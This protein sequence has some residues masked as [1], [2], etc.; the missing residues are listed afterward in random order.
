MRNWFQLMDGYLIWKVVPPDYNNPF[1]P[2]VSEQ[3][4]HE[5][6]SRRSALRR[7]CKLKCLCEG[8]E[9]M[10]FDNLDDPGFFTDHPCISAM[11]THGVLTYVF[12][13]EV[14]VE[15]EEQ[16][17]K[18]EREMR[19]LLAFRE[20]NLSARVVGWG[21]QITIAEYR[22]RRE[23]SKRLLAT[24]SG[25]YVVRYEHTGIA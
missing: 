11:G 16:L 21:D 24:A 19:E 14:N 3:V 9:M 18:I 5:L 22:K 10:T 1:K 23:Q 25:D 2:P 20:Q 17:D 12:G 15:I 7:V 6:V 8:F 4:L 13:S